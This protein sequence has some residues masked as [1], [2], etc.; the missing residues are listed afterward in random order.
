LQC[1]PAQGLVKRPNT[2]ENHPHATRQDQALR[3]K[4]PQ[5]RR[6]GVPQGES[7]VLQAHRAATDAWQ[8][9]RDDR[10]DYLHPTQKP[11]ELA[12]RAIRNHTSPGD[13]VLDAFA[14]SGSTLMA[15][16]LTGRACRT[17]E[18]DPK[19]AAVVIDRWHTLTGNEP[20]LQ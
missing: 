17:I 5:Q 9:S 12:E 1:K 13:I 16:Q 14:G 3:A 20:S 2:H 19:F 15:C 11:T 4:P 8:V 10:K 6:R 18:I 7:I